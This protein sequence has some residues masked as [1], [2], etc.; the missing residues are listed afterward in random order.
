MKFEN[1]RDSV[2]GAND[3]S[4]LDKAFTKYQDLYNLYKLP[5]MLYYLAII[6]FNQKKYMKFQQCYKGMDLVG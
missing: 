2:N 1:K 5:Q 6:Y 3:S 4:H